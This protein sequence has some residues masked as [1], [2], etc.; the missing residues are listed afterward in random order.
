MANWLSTD[1]DT[2]IH[3]PF[4]RLPPKDVLNLKSIVCTGAYLIPYFIESLKCPTLKV[5]RSV[6]DVNSSLNCLGMPEMSAESLEKF[7]SLEY[8]SVDFERVVSDAGVARGVWEY[9]R[10]NDVFNEVRYLQL[11]DFVI[12]DEFRDYNLESLKMMESV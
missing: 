12:T 10:P 11:R 7:D 1:E 5:L 4:G 3:D 8:P 9:L 2:C 6:K